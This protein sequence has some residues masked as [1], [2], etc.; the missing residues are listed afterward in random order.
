MIGERTRP[1]VIPVWMDLATTDQTPVVQVVQ[2]EIQ[3]CVLEALVDK[4][5]AV[6]VRVVWAIKVA[7]LTC[8]LA[9][10]EALAL[11]DKEWVAQVRVAWV[12]QVVLAATLTSALVDQVVILVVQVAILS[13]QVAILTYAQE[14]P[15][16]CH[17]VDSRR[18][19]ILTI[20]LV[21]QQAVQVVTPATC[22]EILSNNRNEATSEKD[23]Q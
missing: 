5:W 1:K 23:K 2:S 18:E 13:D 4:A 19:E 21:A 14:D 16:E 8:V 22:S 12:V 11:V 3:I 7:T 20:V 10:L 6:Q 9:V 17:R 15:A